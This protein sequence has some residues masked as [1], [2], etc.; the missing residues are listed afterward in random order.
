MK[1]ITRNPW[2]PDKLLVPSK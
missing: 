1:R 2:Y